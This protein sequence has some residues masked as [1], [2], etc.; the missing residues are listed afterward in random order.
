MVV[1]FPLPRVS[2][3]DKMESGPHIGKIKKKGILQQKR[4]VGECPWA[5]ETAGTIGLVQRADIGPTVRA[6]FRNGLKGLQPFGPKSGPD[7]RTKTQKATGGRKTKMRKEGQQTAH[8]DDFN[9]LY[10]VW[11]IENE[12]LN[13]F[14]MC[15]YFFLREN[16]YFIL[17]SIKKYFMRKSLFYFIFN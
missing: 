4:V 3:S 12:N 6:D 16:Q 7:R 9:F 11:I 13:Y 1:V 10:F 2:S 17:F 5:R 14:W 15:I 8:T